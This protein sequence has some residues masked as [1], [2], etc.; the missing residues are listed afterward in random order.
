MRFFFFFSSRNRNECLF[1]IAGRNFTSIKVLFIVVQNA[2]SPMEDAEQNG[3]EQCTG[4][5]G[6]GSVFRLT[7]PS[8]DLHSKSRTLQK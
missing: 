2:C 3:A 8:S 7:V 5:K 6:A 1:L 4:L